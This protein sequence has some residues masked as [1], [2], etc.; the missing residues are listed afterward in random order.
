MSLRALRS[1]YGRG[2]TRAVAR[3]GEL[4]GAAR[5]GLVNLLGA[6]FAAVAGLAVTTV[7]A[8]G[9]GAAAAGVFFAATSMFLLAQM[10][11]K[12]GT[13][14]GLV[15]WLARLRALG[16]YDQLRRCLRLGVIPVLIAG[17]LCGAMLFAIAPWLARLPAVAGNAG[18]PA[19]GYVR[20]L[21]VLALFL[22]VAA[23]S[24]TLLSASRGYRTMRPT[25]VVEKVSRPALQLALLAVALGF[26]GTVVD[27]VAWS[28]PYLVSVALA[29]C[30]LSRVDRAQRTVGVRRVPLPG[31]L[32]RAFWRFTAPRALSSI[33]QLALQRLDVV[34]VAAMLGFR[35]AALYAV[36]T[37]FIVVGQLGNQAIGSAV[38]P[39]LAELL[40]RHDIRAV[41]ALYQ[42][43]TAW[44]VLLTWPMYLLVGTFAPMYL[45]VF[46][47]G[48]DERGAVAVVR[49]LCLA[50]LACGACGMVD[51]VLT[52]A[53]RTTWNLANVLLAFGV[54]LAL[55]LLLIPRLG[56]TGAAIGWAV[57][58]LV[59][60]LVPLGQIAAVLR[61]HPFGSATRT[62]ILL[63]AAAT[64]VPAVG[65]KLLLGS[66]F[67]ALAAALTGTA[68]C[69]AAG[70]WLLRDRLGAREIPLPAWIGT[71]RRPP[72]R[73]L[74]ADRPRRRRPEDRPGPRPPVRQ[75]P[76]DE[77]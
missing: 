55:D 77:R 63:C 40:A 24:D 30:W 64:G 76:V 59:K 13:D 43:S 71:R 8:R 7:V 29:A 72:A 42:G 19:G 60:N 2:E 14:T 27:T 61:L 35:A 9:L 44:V 65:A 23:M 6:G 32:A 15:Y 4:G 56:I 12:L 70:C 52:M 48:Y 21:Q 33:A 51:M 53:G 38:Q 16:R 36:A 1:P 49:L 47:G 26:A 5:G 50:M 39:R 20:A 25:V 73:H 22:P 68:A 66:G 54:N 41:R 31:R 3:Q 11:A 74:S 18:A 37:R 45:R 46:G 67:A 28:A 75:H 58:L 17:I 62:A 34:L 69:L 57:A 10:L